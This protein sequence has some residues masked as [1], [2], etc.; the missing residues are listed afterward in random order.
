VDIANNKP[1]IVLIS[2][3]CVRP[4][5]LG[6]Y[7]CGA[8]RTPHLDR[9][10]AR[11]VVFDQA[12]S[13]APNTWVSHAGILTGCY[14]PLHGL[15][16]A[17]DGILEEVPTLAEILKGCGYATAGFPGND[18]VGSRMGFGRGF[19]L[20]FEEYG[21][22]ETPEPE[23]GVSFPDAGP[24]DGEEDRRIT[25]NTRN[26]WEEVLTSAGQWLSREKE[27]VFLWF[28][29]LDTHHLPDLR[30][31]EYFRFSQDPQ[32][33][34]YEGKISYADERCVGAVLELLQKHGRCEDALIAVLSDHGEGLWPGRPPLHNGELTDDAIRVP[35]ILFGEC[36][37]VRGVRVGSLVRTVDL[38]PTLAARAGFRDEEALERFSG[39]PLPLPGMTDS[40]GGKVHF[41]GNAAY[42]ENEPLG[43]SCIRTDEWKYLLR[44]GEERLFHLP[45]DPGEQMNL[46][47]R[48]PETA[49]GLRRD[50][51][52]IRSRGPDRRQAAAREEQETH[53][54]LRSLG[55]ME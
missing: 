11:G 22:D 23:Q 19:D 45:T 13:Q 36:L 49:G 34:Y 52:R 48:H 6:C 25:A 18:L 4:D 16:S 31:P 50:L 24:R 27:P 9:M 35:L 20:F 51:E 1:N 21:P 41:S 8:V 5:F 33:Q 46:V 26:D 53:R 12:V 39:V 3:D 10:A 43:L 29:Y 15:R 28:H 40:T 30:L 42:A 7:G 14:P 37:P 54:L 38:V 47:P 17:Y 2:L 44:G 55:Y 32:W